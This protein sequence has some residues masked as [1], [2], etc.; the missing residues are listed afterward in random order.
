[1]KKLLFIFL[2][3]LIIIFAVEYF[4]CLSYAS[5]GMMGYT[6]GGGATGPGSKG[7]NFV[8]DANVQAV[9]SFENA[10][11]LKDSSILG[12]DLTFLSGTAVYSSTTGVQYGTYSANT[13]TAWC[14]Y[15]A[16]A[17][18]SAAFPG[19]VTYSAMTALG[20]INMTSAPG[21][22]YARLLQLSDLSTKGWLLYL[23]NTSHAAL[24]IFDNGGTEQI[25]TGGTALSQTTEYLIAGVWDGTHLHIYYAA[26][27]DCVVHEDATAVSW[28]GSPSYLSTLALGVLS[29]KN[30]TACFGP[31][32]GYNDAFG[33]F[34]R[35]F[36]TIE[37]ASICT[38][39]ID[40]SK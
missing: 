29:L 34:N 9:Y 10:N 13:S 7:T 26:I 20:F 3:P 17:D 12:N 21:A 25:V 33:V 14:A 18:L 23:D 31:M 35:S 38:H 36:S 28:S 11:G 40:G 6:G 16:G 37:L 5:P 32:Q 8:T 22:S 4:A 24:G 19:K 39:G 27:S 2:I 1:M 15:R 30:S